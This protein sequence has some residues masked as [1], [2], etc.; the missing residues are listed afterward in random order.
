MLIGETAVLRVSGAMMP[1][2]IE[3]GTSIL[4][5]VGVPDTWTHVCPDTGQCCRRKRL[6]SVGMD[7]ERGEPACGNR[8][9]AE[10]IAPGAA[11]ERDELIE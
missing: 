2:Y 10:P 9:A 11:F 5:S 6:V 3:F 4:E 8:I 1:G 7:V